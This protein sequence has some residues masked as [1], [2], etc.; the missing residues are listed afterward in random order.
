[1]ADSITIMFSLVVF[2]MAIGAILWMLI[3]EERQ[4]DM[5][6]KDLCRKRIRFIRALRER[7]VR[8]MPC[9]V[10]GHKIWYTQWISKQKKGGQCLRCHRSFTME[11]AFP[12]KVTLRPWPKTS[13]K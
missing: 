6:Y 13:E 7:F 4:E 5:T 1:M 11:I 8:R 9:S 12:H 2:P 3:L 10:V